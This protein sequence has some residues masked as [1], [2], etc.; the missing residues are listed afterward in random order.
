MFY[1]LLCREMTFAFV[2]RGRTISAGPIIYVAPPPSASPRMPASQPPAPLSP[3]PSSLSG[4]GHAR[5]KRGGGPTQPEMQSFQ[6]VNTNNMVDLFTG[7][8]SY[9]I[10][11]LDV[12]GYPL[13]LS[14]Q[15]G[16]TMDQD[17]SWV[18]LGWN[19]NPGTIARNMRGLPDDFNGTDRVTK[20]I[21]M[22]DDK[23]VGVTAAGNVELVGYPIGGNL[24]LSAGIF[25]NTYKGWG[26]ETG[27][28][29]GINS[30]VGSK[31]QL[32]GNLSITNNS[33]TGLDVSP[34]FAFSL[35]SE[36]NKSRGTISIG[37]NYNSRTG[38]Q[39]LQLTAEYRQ[40]IN[41]FQ[42]D[43]YSGNIGSAISSYISFATPSYT[44]QINI[45]FTSSQFTYKAKVGGEAWALHPNVSVTGY[46]STQT[47]LPADQVQ[48]LPAFGYLY[49]QNAGS[50][51]HV[52]LD[53]NRD[54]EVTYRENVPTIG[55][56]SYT[57]DAWSISGEGTG[58]MFRAYRGDI[59]YIF[60][61]SM[62][63]KS[64][65]GAFTVDL[66]FGNIF[67]GG[68]DVNQV[69]ASTQNGPWTGDNL[70]KDVIGF[71]QRDSIF[72]NV[73]FKNPGEKTLVNQTFYDAIGDVNLV[74]VDLDPLNGQNASVVTATRNLSIFKNAKF[75]GRSTLTNTNTLRL[76]RD[77]RNQLISYLTAQQ[78]R[79]AGLD[80]MIRS[81]YI[82]N[83]PSTSCNYNYQTFPRVD[84]TVHQ[85][86]HI[87]E[88][89]VTNTDG[90]RYVYGIPVYNISQ[91][92]AS[93][94][95]NTGDSKAGL[96]TYNQD[97]LH[98]ENSV[99]NN[100]GKDY[101]FN[102]EETPAY[103]HSFLLSAILSPDYI[104]ITGDGVSEDDQGEAIRFNY[105]R[106]YGPGNYYQ[107]RAPYFQNQA[108]YNEGMKTDSRDERGSYSYGSREVWYMNSLESKNMIATFT[109]E[110]DTIRKDGFGV[111]GENGGLN[112]GNKLY[113]LRQI[114]LY[115]KADFL[116]N[117]ITKAKA[118]K[119]VHFEY[120]YTLCPGNPAS[121]GAGV[122]K[123]TLKKVW[124]TY[125]SNNKGK[126]NPYVF[127]YHNNN[128]S[129][130][131]KS[132]DRW[133]NYKN[134]AGN[135]GNTGQELSNA[136]YP[137]TLQAGV[138]SWDSVQA[139]NSAS[140]WTLT[141]VKLPSGGRIAVT[142]ES[143][144][145]A[146][147]Q[148]RRAM[149][150]FQVLGFGPTPTSS[151][152][153]SLYSGT[154]NDY[155]F[156]FVKVPVGVTDR[157]DI[158]RKYL[159]G[160]SRLYF[161]LFVK[162]PADRWG[163]GSEFVPCFG[164]IEDYGIAGPPANNTIWIRVAAVNGHSPMAEAAIQFLRLNLPSK[165]YPFSEPGDNVSVKDVVKMILSA[166]SN[167]SDAV[168]G[169]DASAR[170]RNWCNS[171]TTEKSFVRL[172]NPGYNKLGGG[173]RVKRIQIFDNWNAMTGQKES[174]YGQEYDYS[175]TAMINGVATRISSGVASY[176]PAVGK[177]ESPFYLPIE[178]VEK[179]SA[180]APTN[181]LYTE[182]PL[183]ESYFPSPMVGYRKVRVQTIHKDKQS[184][185]GLEE[186]EFYTTYDFPTL[187]EFTPLDIQ[188]KK[189]YNP[190]VANFLKI[191]AKHDVT[192]SQG[193]KVE[194]N[195]MNG[196]MRSQSSYAQTDL[197][198]PI[199]YTYN[200][201]KLDNVNS[202]TPH[203]SNLAVV[204]DSANGGLLNGQIGK[205]IDM[206][207]DLR[208]QTSQTSSG[209]VEV[210]V[211][212]MIAGF[213]PIS[214]G[215][216]IP[217]P[218]SERNRFRSVAVMKVVQRYGIL[219]SVV[220][221]DKGSL[222]SVRN[223]VYDGET[224]EALLSKTVNAFDDP[225]YTWNYP[226]HWAYS[227]M[228]P[229]Y[230][231]IGAVF[232][233]KNFRQGRMLNRDGSVFPA[234]R[235]FES[236]DEL[237]A[238]GPAFRFSFPGIDICN[239]AY[240]FYYGPI[241][242]QRVWAVDISK[243]LEGYKG[244]YFIDQ[245]GK[246]FSGTNDS[247]VIIRSGKRN[248][249]GQPVGSITSLQNPIRVVG[250]GSR[251]II[252]SLSGVLAASA[253][254]FKD[255]WRTDSSFYR[256]DTTMILPRLA[257]TVENF[258]SPAE[259]F[260]LDMHNG[261]RALTGVPNTKDFDA[262][263]NDLGG[264]GHSD[265][266]RKS[267]LRWDLW[268]NGSGIP[269][270]S[271]IKNST[272]SLT[273]D[274]IKWD[275]PPLLPD[276]SDLNNRNHTV[277]N[278]SWLIR[279]KG[280]WMPDIWKAT[281][282]AHNPLAASIFLGMMRNDQPNVNVDLTT[283][284][285]LPATPIGQSV[286]RSDVFNITAMTQG[287]LDDFYSSNRKYPPATLIELQD[288]TGDKGSDKW[289]RLAYYSGVGV[290]NFPG[291]HYAL[292]APLMDVVYCLPCQGT[293]KPVFSNTPVP[294]YYC[295]SKP[296]DTFVCRSNINDTATNPYRWGILGNW[297]MSKAYTYYNSR[298]E[299]DATQTQTNI[300]TD[301]QIM[302]FMPYWSFSSGKMQAS[303]DSSRWVWNSQ[304]DRFNLKGYE[305]ENHDPLGRYNSGQYGYN[306]T[307]PVAVTQ[308]GKNRQM[309][310]DGFEDYGYRT[311]TCHSCTPPRF[312]D[313]TK[314]GGT[315]V[316]SVS[317]TGVYSLRLGGNQTAN[318]PFQVVSL[319]TDTTSP[320][321]SMKLDSTALVHTTVTGKGHGLKTE[322]FMAI[323]APLINSGCS[324]T[325]MGQWITTTASTVNFDMATT[326]P[327]P[328]CPT[329]F[330]SARWTG[331]IQPRYSET[332][333]FYVTCDDYIKI[334]INDGT[335][336]REITTKRD[337]IDNR[338]PEISH[339][340]GKEYATDT[341]T[342]QAGG[343][344]TISIQYT[345]SSGP[346]FALVSWA[347]TSQAKEILPLSQLYL[348]T[349][350]SSDTA[351][352]TRRD[353]TWCV[354][355][356]N[357]KPNKVQRTAFSP[358][359]GT[360]MLVS[361]WVKE[362]VPCISGSYANEQVVV[363]FNTGASFTL[364]P[365]GNIIEGWQRVEDTVLVPATAVSMTFS[366]KS[367]SATAVFFDD[368]RMHPFNADM[369][370]YVYNPVNLRLMAELDENNYATFYEYDDDGTLIRVK[371]ETERGIMTIK[372]TRSA[373]LKDQ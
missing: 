360:K 240:Y 305:I 28:N 52:L 110:T 308:N 278:A 315:L 253:M 336:Q 148:N 173:L 29:A 295:T 197:V 162:M 200:Y 30:G 78:A 293:T 84:A 272:L 373:L 169:F 289:S 318:I 73:Y 145:Y 331:V 92:N 264:N 257:D 327:Q 326:R 54:K 244:I 322:Y 177:E 271:V 76:Q 255:F 88:V 37:T 41:N 245:D 55:V 165:A 16:I 199:S 7:D 229:A 141:G 48:S 249:A 313:L 188:S 207:V 152:S 94:A 195:D 134:P 217:F 234:E 209:S 106:V 358:T 223:L 369:K 311:D 108:S 157:A 23:T 321:L 242:P 268:Q 343:M 161:K 144:D 59:G 136:D 34:T 324:S 348:P 312:E 262:A 31:G 296:V 72:E 81:Y 44:P 279:T 227:G 350:T 349:W 120:D 11:L 151:I 196:K 65:T 241:L 89:T 224:G 45:P 85:K 193:F 338:T 36:D 236:G 366:M 267:W 269:Q 211:D 39:N 192:L 174:V 103:A 154:N 137:Y 18:G 153:T 307:L 210:N 95:T 202:G 252:D 283:R 5:K 270:G 124:F 186:T 79:V 284:V 329:T 316:D 20:T 222:V 228:E 302:S 317:H 17:A 225:V 256:K 155:R 146:Y 221:F 334:F 26:T 60:D 299:T 277:G 62:S 163:N 121:N 25:H 158:A 182:E 237:L 107:W 150:L 32:S 51:Q 341:I 6:S 275:G 198:N 323:R 361:A 46:G 371:K 359:Q 194:L 185:N 332:Y 49:Y 40:G 231:N 362:D 353:T 64:N 90:R 191:N 290:T 178:Y 164:D 68:V 235:Y 346:S 347:S 135:P 286:Y 351:G 38:I 287:M 19:I 170:K 166:A 128:P 303:Q 337:P 219:D 218:T 159:D 112:A 142:Y 168:N 181:Y 21:S 133:G 220:K 43:K 176:E 355:L 263:S 122:G 98:P 104:D 87:S 230:K 24:G 204:A 352:S 179:T 260:G 113:R 206:M 117:G 160:V 80:T 14:Y 325:P 190:V 12:G 246:P 149:Q 143:D 147:V 273:S 175:T 239:P 254:E 138:K 91:S 109:L 42:K 214:L 282:Q 2:V 9:S 306:Q 251:I 74:R 208:E 340:W 365:T 266:S 171:I 339:S 10:P 56:P 258:F 356:R 310:F 67:H 127:T 156:V 116:K 1:L 368:I 93:F 301:G 212:F 47:I 99:N 129:Y 71:R 119:T 294:G 189:T 203:L 140:A 3:S 314:G 180:L 123:L 114:D 250:A 344:Y 86:H 304:M 172:D 274:F 300:R 319:T 82:N 22:K 364:R 13:N 70:L 4:D 372:E 132:Y 345:Q 243:G 83:F 354:S 213:F 33:Q 53:F 280:I 183:Q 167:I 288:V 57:Y 363:S 281:Q 291:S 130:D 233:G 357:V 69:D 184:A 118:I 201:Y 131:N 259:A 96:V 97:P 15:S 187:T 370:S 35:A 333:T 100:R 215:S 125:N 261:G 8:F 367:T 247:V 66:G 105:S 115:A 58:G 102:K 50:N 205:D 126:L 226:A 216:F 77:R 248:M 101:Y 328:W 61:H 335:R 292:A 238:Y 27:V 276:L 320:T 139:A 342:L 75:A 111:L 330:F 63:T 298:K 309:A 285:S 265:Y 232:A 297:R